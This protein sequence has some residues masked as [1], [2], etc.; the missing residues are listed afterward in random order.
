V[1]DHCDP[2]THSDCD[3]LSATCEPT[4]SMPGALGSGTACEPCGIGSS[5]RSKS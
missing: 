3:M 5:S 4:S 2:A 1:G